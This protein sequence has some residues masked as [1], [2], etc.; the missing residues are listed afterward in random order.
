MRLDDPQIVALLATQWSEPD[1]GS[2]FWA[3]YGI[4]A[5][6]RSEIVR[7]QGGRC[8]ICTEEAALVVDH[9]HAT[10]RAR[11]LI[12]GRCNTG[13]GHA[14]DS[15][16][17]LRAK[18]ARYL[19]AAEY[20]DHSRAETAAVTAWHERGRAVQAKRAEV[21]AERAVER[22]RSQA[23]ADTKARQLAAEQ[24]IAEEARRQP[25]I[26]ALW[27]KDLL[28]V[29]PVRQAVRRFPMREGR[30]TMW[31]P[32][33]KADG[34]AN[35]IDD[36][37]SSDADAFVGLRGITYTGDAMAF[38]G[39][40]PEETA[41]Y[42][43]AGFVKSFDDSVRKYRDRDEA[44]RLIGLVNAAVEAILPWGNKVHE[45][46]EKCSVVLPKVPD[47]TNDR[48]ADLRTPRE[49]VMEAVD[50]WRLTLDRWALLSVVDP[51]SRV[52]P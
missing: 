6:V 27:P 20:L 36:F 28:R 30:W 42:F 21:V 15:P 45:W 14:D 37:F 2:A 11:G 16:D 29:F 19:R 46:H 8:R 31:C 1:D 17:A 7:L 24:A 10:G 51:S 33:D 52:A 34:I 50:L 25:D 26:L 13:L 38:S 44:D 12:C 3:T 22:A 23:I 18:A 9:C 32:V 47:L 5:A 48:L 43:V 35:R 41:G 39:L 40:T 49:L 4:T